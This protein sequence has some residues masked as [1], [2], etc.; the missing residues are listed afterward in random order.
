MQQA[1]DTF[2]QGKIQ[3]LFQ[4]FNPDVTQKAVAW[5]LALVQS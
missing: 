1:Y 5:A 2:S 4:A 3:E